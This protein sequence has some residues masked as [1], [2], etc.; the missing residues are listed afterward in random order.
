MTSKLGPKNSRS[1]VAWPGNRAHSSACGCASRR[2]ETFP[3]RAACNSYPQRRELI[4]RI[5]ADLRV[6]GRK[7]LF[8]TKKIEV[9]PPNMR[10]TAEVDPFGGVTIFHGGFVL[11]A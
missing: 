1:C 10:Q 8:Q 4:A 11:G 6:G 5:A 9:K 3:P 2:V 7:T